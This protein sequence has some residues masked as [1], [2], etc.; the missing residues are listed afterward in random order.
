RQAA[1]EGIARA[2]ITEDRG[3][4]PDHYA[5]VVVGNLVLRSHRARE[6]WQASEEQRSPEWLLDEIIGAD[7]DGESDGHGCGLKRNGIQSSCSP[8]QAISRPVPTNKANTTT[9]L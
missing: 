8:H 2:Q 1:V 3:G 9:C 7:R 6:R 4:I 5:G